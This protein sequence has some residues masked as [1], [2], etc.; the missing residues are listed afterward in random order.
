MFYTGISHAGS[1][2]I[3]VHSGYGILKYEEKTSAF[4]TNVEAKSRQN[5]I[6]LG[7][8][9]EYSFQKLKNFYA[10]VT[11][12]WAFGMG[13]T[14]KWKENGI[15]TQTNDMEVFGQFYDLRFGYKNNLDNFNYRFYASGGWDGIN[16]KRDEFIWRGASAADRVTEDFSLWRTGIGAG[17]GYKLNQ[18]AIDGRAAYS[19]YPKG[20][21][22]NS[23]F[24]QFE[25]D[26]DGTCLDL[27]VG[28]A[29]EIKKNLKF[30]IGGSYTLLK[31]NQSDILSDSSVRAVFPNSKTEMIIGVVNLTYTF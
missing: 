16:F 31:L 11:T 7:G 25:F 4:G 20:T 1:F 13:D 24:P 12:D 15:Q 22:E 27:G 6:L 21:V 30:Y 26:T 3:G 10:G 18:W 29:S 28:I 23:S 19:Y 2:G 17:A 5:V 14:E 8:S 9:G